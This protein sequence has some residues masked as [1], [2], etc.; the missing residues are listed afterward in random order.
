MTILSCQWTLL[1]F[2]IAHD[3][4]S[5]ILEALYHQLPW[6]GN[7]IWKA[8][9]AFSTEELL[10][11]LEQILIQHKWRVIVTRDEK[12]RKIK[13]NSERIQALLLFA[14][15]ANCTINVKLTWNTNWFFSLAIE[16]Q[17]ENEKWTVLMHYDWAQCSLFW[18]SQKRSLCYC[19]PFREYGWSMIRNI[20]NF[21][22]GTTLCFYDEQSRKR[23]S[24]DDYRTDTFELQ[25]T[26]FINFFEN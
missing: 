19:Y 24:R 17:K 14:T 18:N 8:I 1:Y 9:N 13:R 23:L 7:M 5:A 2:G 20:S 12:L 25:D 15:L 16:E 26:F 3:C 22:N 6:P 4:D 10:N 11:Q 21:L